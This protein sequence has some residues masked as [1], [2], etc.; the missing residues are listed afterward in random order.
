M[1]RVVLP[2]PLYTLARCVAEVGLTPAAPTLGAVIDALEA[3]HPPLAGLLRDRATGQRRPRVRFYVCQEDWSNQPMHAP[4]PE[5]VASGAEP[6][7][8]VGAISGG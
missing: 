3:A 2:Y 6:L 5:L 8:V 7:L 1:I 4:L